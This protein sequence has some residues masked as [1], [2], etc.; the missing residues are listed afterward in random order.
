MKICA[1]LVTL[2]AALPFAAA[3]RAQTCDSFVGQVV[4]PQSFGAAATAL[5]AIPGVKGEFETTMEFEERQRAAMGTLPSHLVISTP[6]DTEYIDYDAD[7]G[8]FDIRRYAVNN[9]NTDYARI[10]G[11]SGAFEGVVS[12]SML[13]VLDV[14]IGKTERRTGSYRAQNAFGASTTVSEIERTTQSIYEGA[15]TTPQHQ[16]LF[17]RTPGDIIWSLPI[18]PAEARE[19]RN[20]FR[21]AWAVVPK[22]PFFIEGEGRGFRATFDVP[23]DVDETLQIVVADIQ[24]ALLLDAANTVLA[25]AT[26]H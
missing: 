2:L 26:T 23:Q 14:V 25:A 7:A 19:A 8:R 6:L 16:G 4:A 5:R 3:S 13:G 10:F 18:S 17:R 22:P 20:Q 1:A 9:V 12:Y 15:D 24:C 21:A 11:T